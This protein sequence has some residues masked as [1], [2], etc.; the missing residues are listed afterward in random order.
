MNYIKRKSW[1]SIILILVLLLFL[2]GCGS[3]KGVGIQENQVNLRTYGKTSVDLNVTPDYVPN[4]FL[5]EMTDSLF[6]FGQEI[7]EEQEEEKE[8]EKEEEV[9]AEILS[10]MN[11]E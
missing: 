4:L 1:I 5:M 6:Y 10:R 8:E 7:V 9:K 3:D 11:E 2:Q